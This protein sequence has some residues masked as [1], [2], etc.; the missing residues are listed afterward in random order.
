MVEGCG[1]ALHVL[2]ITRH[3]LA[4]IQLHVCWHVSRSMQHLYCQ[5][6][7]CCYKCS[8]LLVYGMTHVDL[9]DDSQRYLLL[10]PAPVTTYGGLQEFYADI[11]RGPRRLPPPTKP[12]NLSQLTAADPAGLEYLN[13]MTKWLL[14]THV[15]FAAGA[16]ADMKERVKQLYEE[17]G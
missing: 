6:N 11:S 7:S 17:V 8:I 2:Q 5:A 13:A 4:V 16:H 10:V 9:H 15:Q 1:E 12:A 3:S 14:Q